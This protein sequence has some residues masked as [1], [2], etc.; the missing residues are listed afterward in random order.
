MNSDF[1][2][3]YDGFT[4]KQSFIVPYQHQPEYGKNKGDKIKE[5]RKE[6]FFS[7]RTKGKFFHLFTPNIEISTIF[8]SEKLFMIPNQYIGCSKYVKKT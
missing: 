7:C 2:P 6:M 3:K 1:C 8:Q 4:Q 5:T